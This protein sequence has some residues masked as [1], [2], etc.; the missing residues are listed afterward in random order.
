M[1]RVLLAW[2][3]SCDRCKLAVTVTTPRLPAPGTDTR[4]QRTHT[5]PLAPKGEGTNPLLFLGIS[6]SSAGDKER[7]GERAGVAERALLSQGMASAW[8]AFLTA[9]P[10]RGGAAGDALLLQP[11]PMGWWGSTPLPGEPWPGPQL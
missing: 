10:S 9:L 6:S 8:V 7:P 4:A 1:K 3:N 5:H 2:D 11:P